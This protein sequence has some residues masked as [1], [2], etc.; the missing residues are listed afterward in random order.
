MYRNYFMLNALKKKKTNKLWIIVTKLYIDIDIKISI[1]LFYSF[2]ILYEDWLIIVA[3]VYIV[4]KCQMFL[5]I[6]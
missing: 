1:L 3:L 2:I 4:V 5:V 6:E